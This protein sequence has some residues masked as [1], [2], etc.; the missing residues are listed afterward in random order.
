M[1]IEDYERLFLLSRGQRRLLGIGSAVA[2]IGAGLLL[3]SPPSRKTLERPALDQP[4]TKITESA[5]DTTSVVVTLFSAGVVM[6]IFAVSGT[7]FAK[8]EVPGLK[9]E[10]ASPPIGKLDDSP[11]KPKPES[12]EPLASTAPASAHFEKP[13]PGVQT[14]N[15]AQHTFLLRS[16]WHGL[17]ILKAC[18]WAAQGKRLLRLREFA[19]V[20]TP[21]A[22]DYAFGFLIATFSANLVIASANPESGHVVVASVHPTVDERIDEFL[23][24]YIRAHKGHSEELRDDLNAMLSYLKAR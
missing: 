11:S 23:E 8:V 6:L 13:I 15:D 2:F 24:G 4:P 20:G 7:K 17:K 9:L 10:A 1:K 22:Y 18:Q 5:A 3:F 12:A 14:G 19:S 16:S 21:M